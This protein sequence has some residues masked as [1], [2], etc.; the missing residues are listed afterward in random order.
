MSHPAAAQMDRRRLGR[1]SVGLCSSPT[2]CLTQKVYFPRTNPVSSIARHD[3]NLTRRLFRTRLFF[4][5]RCRRS[6]QTLVTMTT[7]RS[8]YKNRVYNGLSVEN[9][10]VSFLIF[11]TQLPSH[12]DATRH[13]FVS[14]FVSRRR[15]E[16]TFQR[17]IRR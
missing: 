8:R 10:L 16:N 15:R 3:E 6:L 7:T 9:S 13:L 17:L 5:A 2:V 14:V 11:G 12:T 4:D 1:S